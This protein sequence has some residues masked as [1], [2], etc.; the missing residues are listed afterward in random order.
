MGRADKP[1]KAIRACTRAGRQF[2]C[3]SNFSASQPVLL[4]H[5]F[6]LQSDLSAAAQNEVNVTLRRRRDLQP[7]LCVAASVFWPV[8]ASSCK[9]SQLRPAARCRRFH[10]CLSK[11]SSSAERQ[12]LFSHLLFRH[13]FALPMRLRRSDQT[14]PPVQFARQQRLAHVSL[15][16]NSPSLPT[17]SCSPDDAA[18]GISEQCP[19]A[20][21]SSAENCSGNFSLSNSPSLLTSSCFS[22]EAVS[23][24][25][26]LCACA[27][28][29]SVESCSCNSLPTSFCSPDDAASW[30]W[31]LRACPICSSTESCSCNFTTSN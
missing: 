10:L 16:S 21:C 25:S 18:L 26:K 8:L 12:Q 31:K 29:W 15:V 27:A 17:S 3:F 11:A 30:A 13:S 7:A 1:P 14:C 24:I 20:I 9:H 6:L 19:C 2:Q 28:C 22:D 4:R 5:V 23:C